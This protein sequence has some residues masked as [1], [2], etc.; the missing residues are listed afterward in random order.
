MAAKVAIVV[1]IAKAEKSINQ[2]E[3]KKKRYDMGD[4]RYGGDA[5]LRLL[6]VREDTCLDMI[7]H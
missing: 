7:L 4:M 6:S 2:T 3:E 1:A 5:Y